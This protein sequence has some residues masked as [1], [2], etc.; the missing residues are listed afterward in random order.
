[1]QNLYI[2]LSLSSTPSLSPSPS[3]RRGLSRAKLRRLGLISGGWWVGGLAGS[4]G[5]GQVES[6]DSRQLS[7]GSGRSKL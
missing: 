5:R 3:L 2:A 4:F 7:G 1:M 6:S